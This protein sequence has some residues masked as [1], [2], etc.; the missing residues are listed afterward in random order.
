MLKYKK[1]TTYR[2]HYYMCQHIDIIHYS[3][4]V[5]KFNIMFDS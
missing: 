4:A 3:I 1:V 5:Y 2:H